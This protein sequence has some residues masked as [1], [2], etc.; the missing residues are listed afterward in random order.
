MD[1]LKTVQVPCIQR[2]GILLRALNKDMDED[3]PSNNDQLGKL[4]ELIYNKLQRQITI[5]IFKICSTN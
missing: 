2:Y 5:V 3:L 4:W 1:S